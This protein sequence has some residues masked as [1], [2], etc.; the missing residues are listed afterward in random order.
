MD[1]SGISDMSRQKAIATISNLALLE[2]NASILVE[3]HTLKKLLAILKPLTTSLAERHTDKDAMVLLNTSIRA[4]GRLSKGDKQMKVYIKHGGF[5]RIRDCITHDKTTAELVTS[6]LVSLVATASTEEGLTALVAEKKI[7]EEIVETVKK[8]GSS[9]MVLHAWELF[10]EA[11]CKE[12][13]G[14]QRLEKA[15]AV[16]VIMKL[17]TDNMH[18]P[19]VLIPLIRALRA[20]PPELLSASVAEDIVSVTVKALKSHKGHDEVT[21]EVLQ[22]L[23]HVAKESETARKAL[24]SFE[25]SHLFATMERKV[26]DEEQKD[27]L[28]DLKKQS[29]RVMAE[30]VDLAMAQTKKL[31]AN[32]QHA[33]TYELPD[34]LS[35]LVQY[36]NSLEMASEDPEMLE[37]IINFEFKGHGFAV[38]E[39]CM[40]QVFDHA[41]LDTQLVVLQSLANVIARAVDQGF[42]G[43]YAAVKT[44]ALE[45]AF[46]ICSE[47]PNSPQMM[48]TLGKIVNSL[49]Q[50]IQDAVMDNWVTLNSG[51]SLA[52]AHIAFHK[53]TAVYETYQKGLEATG[54]KPNKQTATLASEMALAVLERYSTDAPDLQEAAHRLLNSLHDLEGFEEDFEVKGGVS[55]LVGIIQEHPDDEDMV[56]A[57]LDLLADYSGTDAVK[58]VRNWHSSRD[59]AE[60]SLEERRSKAIY[61]VFELLEHPDDDGKHLFHK[62]GAVEWLYDTNNELVAEDLPAF[63]IDSEVAKILI[64]LLT[65]TEQTDDVNKAAAAIIA[66]M[67]R[68]PNLRELFMEQDILDEL[69]KKFVSDPLGHGKKYIL[70][71]FR[72]LIHDPRAQKTIEQAIR[73]SLET[74]DLENPKNLKEV[75]AYIEEVCEMLYSEPACHETANRCVDYSVKL[76][77]RENRPQE[78]ADIMNLL[79]KIAAMH[80]DAA[81]YVSSTDIS[82]RSLLISQGGRLDA[83][84]AVHLICEMAE[85][86][87]NIPYLFDAGARSKMKALMFQ[88]PHDK[89]L[90]HDAQKAVDLMNM[91]SQKISDRERQ[92]FEDQKSAKYFLTEF[93]RGLAVEI[94]FYLA[95][96]ERELRTGDT[97]KDLRSELQRQLNEFAKTADAAIRDNSRTSVIK[98]LAIA[99]LCRV[100]MMTYNFLV[101]KDMSARAMQGAHAPVGHC[102]VNRLGFAPLWDWENP[103]FANTRIRVRGGITHHT[104]TTVLDSSLISLPV[105]EIDPVT[106][107]VVGKTYTLGRLIDMVKAHD[108]PSRDL[109]VST[110]ILGWIQRN[111]RAV[112]LTA[113]MRALKKGSQIREK[114]A[115]LDG[116]YVAERMGL[117]W[118]WPKFIEEEE[119][120]F[121]KPNEDY[122]VVKMATARPDEMKQGTLIKVEKSG[123]ALATKRRNMRDTLDVRVNILTG[124]QREELDFF[125]GIAKQGVDMRKYASSMGKPVDVTVTVFVGDDDEFYFSAANKNKKVTAKHLMKKA[126]HCME[127]ESVSPGKASKVLRAT[128]RKV[129]D[130]CCFALKTAGGKKYH[131]QAESQTSRDMWV[132]GL[133]LVLAI[134][135]G[136]PIDEK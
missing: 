21:H 62:L 115:D 104:V 111:W 53:I 113:S 119:G 32:I 132:R 14:A 15:G 37:K 42:G 106:R 48:V 68:N 22:T 69:C 30:N 63:P 52:G 27:I 12:T 97:E 95:N 79:S 50:A 66:R 41:P 35:R 57:S 134:V 70:P 61:E 107:K 90:F 74:D 10:V 58:E 47:F 124:D 56:A 46:R 31:C 101:Q 131:L 25:L 89:Q 40:E 51:E 11:T 133:H 45:T 5:Q 6:C 8:F 84:S 7:I 9:P 100:V 98:P 118:D 34:L 120:Y 102:L 129:E 135:S 121:Q 73:D 23:V 28:G 92:E 87:D 109:G 20:F 44:G 72:E 71:I 94:S 67:C 17:L 2:A 54:M 19:G 29:G 116:R 117:D 108:D 82:K 99:W 64:H 1:E 112:T 93:C 81:R 49:D 75:L 83:R 3:N 126:V 24:S 26:D 43:A 77:D 65:G 125:L 91:H 122:L 88:Y 136:Q 80:D 105:R 4:A 110:L 55:R 123:E 59:C 78:K 86:Q 85:I 76:L 38:L 18:D 96:S 39:V 13:D 33:D 103:E 114:Y 36:S 128:S 16:N 60:D 130:R 127:I